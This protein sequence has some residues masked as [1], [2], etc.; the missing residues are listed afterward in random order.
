MIPFVVIALIF[1]LLLSF[2]LVPIAVCVNTDTN[3]YFVE[4]KGFAKAS[5][6]EH[7]EEIIRI[8]L[9]V[10]FLSF[11]IY[12]LRRRPSKKVKASKHKNL[13]KP[14]K[15]IPLN[16]VLKVVRTFKTVRFLINIDTGDC[17]LNAKIYPLF[18]LLNYSG[19][20]CHVNFQGRNQLVLIL[21]NRPINIIKSFINF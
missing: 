18:A 6:Q 12:P 19:S 21:K 8:R 9:K 14:R 2:L 4:L 10:L 7:T 11:Y 20:N 13:S 15:R 3:Q 16:R 5:L 1:L 17:I